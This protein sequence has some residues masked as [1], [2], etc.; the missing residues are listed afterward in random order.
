MLTQARERRSNV[1]SECLLLAFLL[2]EL[3]GCLRAL[4]ENG[5]SYTRWERRIKKKMRERLEEIKIEK[6]RREEI[7]K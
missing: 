5:K 2:C 4:P 3:E 1:L 7:R 6:K